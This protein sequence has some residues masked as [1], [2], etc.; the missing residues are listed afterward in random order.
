MRKR[1]TRSHVIADL[2]VNHLERHVLLCG[3]TAERVTHDYGIDMMIHSYD[4][5]GEVE[6]DAIYVQLKATEHMRLWEDQRTIAFEVERSDLELWL[7]ERMPVILILY[8]AVVEVAY[9]L[10]I[11][12]Y[13]ADR[14][15]F[16][17][18]QAGNTVTLHIPGANVVDQHAIRRFAGFKADVQRQMKGLVHRDE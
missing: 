9:W 13:F 14:T 11:Q 12:A 6:P 5:N 2:S 3:F 4:A 15:N 1:R 18:A 16:D 17:L 7:I 10:Y 8:D